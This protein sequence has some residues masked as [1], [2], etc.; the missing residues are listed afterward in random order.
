MSSETDAVVCR[1]C[2]C[3]DPDPCLTIGPAGEPIACSW[4]EE[5]LCSECAA[6]AE[7]TPRPLLYDAGGRPLVFR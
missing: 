5:G 6:P 3:S 2:G 4:A 1:V 7:A